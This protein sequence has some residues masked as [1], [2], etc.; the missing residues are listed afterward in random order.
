[1]VCSLSSLFNYFAC[2]MHCK[3][4]CLLSVMYIVCILHIILTLSLRRKHRIRKLYFCSIFKGGHNKI[5]TIALMFERLLTEKGFLQN[6]L[7]FNPLPFFRWNSMLNSMLCLVSYVNIFCSLLN[8]RCS[9]HYTR[10]YQKNTVLL[11]FFYKSIFQMYYIMR[12]VFKLYAVLKKKSQ[13]I[14][15]PRKLFIM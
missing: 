5:C 8:S 10:I 13:I 9:A 12:L 6:F 11:V 1:M 4:C 15:L 14:F 7:F 2:F 3:T